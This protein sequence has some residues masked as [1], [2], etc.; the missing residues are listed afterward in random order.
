L[1]PTKSKMHELHRKSSPYDIGLGCFP[2]PRRLGKD[3]FKVR[4][5]GRTTK[6]LKTSKKTHMI[7]GRIFVSGGFRVLRW[8]IG[9]LVSIENKLGWSAKSTVTWVGHVCHTQVTWV[10][11]VCQT[12]VMRVWYVCQTQGVSKVQ[13]TWTWRLTKS[14]VT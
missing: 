8:L 6:S 14:K 11:Y 10:L 7:S 13:S 5:L 12:Q 3:K 4:E 2:D 9:F 1:T